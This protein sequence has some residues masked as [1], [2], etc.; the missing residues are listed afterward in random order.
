MKSKRAREAA[1]V[2]ESPVDVVAEVPAKKRKR[3]GDQE[4]DTTAV[5][6]SKKDKKD[7]KDKKKDKKE[8]RKEKKEKR[9]DLLN[10]PEE[11]EA[12]EEQAEAPVAPEPEAKAKAVNGTDKDKKDKKKE[13]KDKKKDK[14]EKEKESKAKEATNGEESP[15]DLDATTATKADRH[16]VFVGNLP[17][18]ATATT[19]SAHFASLSPIAVRCLKNKDDDNPCRGI[20]FVEFGKVWHQRTCL[21]KFHHSMFNDGVSAPRRINVEL[22]AG[23]GGKTKQRQNKIREK[24]IKLDENRAKRI[25][26]EKTTKTE[27]K[28]QE[29]QSNMEDNI[30]P[31][32]RGR[33]PGMG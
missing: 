33:V 30:H 11:D 26:K 31:S 10:L 8:S 19:I 18:S 25:E 13:K 29:A 16:I 32:R 24:N 22:T 12:P 28:Q 23:G 17:F 27:S 3:D 6:K 2:D 14:K 9:K 1:E 7:K 5:K 4:D 15:I 20:A 21:D